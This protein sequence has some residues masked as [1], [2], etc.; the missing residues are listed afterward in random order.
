MTE[1][2]HKKPTLLSS[3]TI[4]HAQAQEVEKFTILI[5]LSLVIMAIYIIYLI[6]SQQ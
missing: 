2:L 1:P 3:S 5:Y 4:D 6:Y